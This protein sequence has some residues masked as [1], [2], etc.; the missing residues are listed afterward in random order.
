MVV[1]IVVGPLAADMTKRMRKVGGD[2]AQSFAHYLPTKS[3]KEQAGLI[4]Y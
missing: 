4:M 2:L 1:F 3:L